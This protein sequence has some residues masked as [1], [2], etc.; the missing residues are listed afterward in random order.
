MF[1]WCATYRWKDFEEGYIRGLHKKLFVYKVEG[2]PI[3]GILGLPT[4]GSR[5]KMK[6]GCKP[7]AMHKKYYKGKGDGF[8]QVRALV[9]FMNF[10]L[11]VV[12]S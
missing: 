2:V 1:K 5:D 9:H 12:R 7:C 6:F 11:F 4:W 10:Y 8:P 3:L